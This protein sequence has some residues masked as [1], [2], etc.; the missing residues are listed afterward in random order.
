MAGTFDF[1]DERLGG[2]GLREVDPD[3]VDSGAVGGFEFCGELF[4]LIFRAGGEDEVASLG[5]V[6]AGEGGSDAS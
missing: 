4:E 6:L 1:I 3:G 5:G 2:L